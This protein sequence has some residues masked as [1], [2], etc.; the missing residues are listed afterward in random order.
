M[1]ENLEYIRDKGIAQFLEKEKAKWKCPKCG[2]IIC[3]HNGLCLSCEVDVLR[4][5]KNIYRWDNE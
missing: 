1:I 4:N 5:K 2:G 3:C